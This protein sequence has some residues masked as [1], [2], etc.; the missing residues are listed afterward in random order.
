MKSTKENIT[1]LKPIVDEKIEEI[2]KKDNILEIKSELEVFKINL[3]SKLSNIESQ[4][5]EISKLDKILKEEQSKTN[6]LEKKIDIGFKDINGIR[7]GID[8]I[9]HMQVAFVVMN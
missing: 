4:F 2:S 8:S 3:E 1:K 9:P 5:A 7:E 6:Q